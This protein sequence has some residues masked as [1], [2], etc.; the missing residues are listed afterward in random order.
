MKT[1]SARQTTGVDV[2][3]VAGSDPC[4]VLDKQLVNDTLIV[5]VKPTD[6]PVETLVFENMPKGQ[7]YFGVQFV[8]GG[9]CTVGV[10]E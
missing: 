5:V 10:M 1:V 4:K 2:V 9:D 7:F 6:F 3:L 8:Q